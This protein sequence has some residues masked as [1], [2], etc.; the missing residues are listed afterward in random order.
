[1]IVFLRL[2]VSRPCHG[3]LSRGPALRQVPYT[4]S[5][6]HINLWP[7]SFIS[8]YKSAYMCSGEKTGGDLS[9]TPHSPLRTPRS[10]LK[11]KKRSKSRFQSYLCF[12]NTI[13]SFDS[14]LGFM[15][16]YGI[17]NVIS[18]VWYFE[19]SFSEPSNF[20]LK[21]NY[22]ALLNSMWVT[23]ILLHWILY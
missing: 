18:M 2:S 17:S 6:A 7:L 11:Y 22:V 20:F 21:K 5:H 15:K 23:P 8:F 16:W 1:M 3:R 10:L 4:A 14:F 9:G 13:F 19:F 12:F